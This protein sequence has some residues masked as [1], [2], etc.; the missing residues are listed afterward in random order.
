M[1]RDCIDAINGKKP[2]DL[3]IRNVRIINVFS[4][5]LQEGDIAICGDTIAYVGKM[6]FPNTAREELD[7]QG[8]YAIP[9]LID[10]HMHIESSMMVPARFA[11]LALACGTTTVAADPHEIGNVFGV[12]GV[13]ALS[14]AAAGSPLHVYMLAPSTIPSAP[15]LETTGASVGAKE[16]AEMLDLPHI[17]GMGEVMDFNGVADGEEDILSVVET[18]RTQG[19]LM[20]AHVTRL[21]GRRL[22]AFR[23]TGADADHTDT[24]IPYARE[25]LETGFAIQVQRTFL[26]AELME[27]LESYP[28]QDRIMLITDDVPFIELVR[29]GHLNA[30]LREAI[31]LGLDPIRAVR[32]ATLNAAD[33]LRLYDRGAVSPGYKADI[34]L[35]DK[36]EEMRPSLVLSDGRVAVKD[37]KCIAQIPDYTFPKHFYTSV[38]VPS[39][40]A[41][42]FV[43]RTET[44]ASKALVNTIGCGQVN[45]RTEKAEKWVPVKNGVLDTQELMKMAVIYRHGKGEEKAPEKKI[46][47]G[48]I[49]G[50]PEF[51]GAIATTY[52][53]DS[54]NL[55]IYGSCDED[56]ALAG[57]HLAEMGGGLCA[58]QDGKVVSQVSLPVAGLLSEELVETLRQEFE[59]FFAAVEKLSLVHEHPMTFLTLMALA[60]SPEIKCTDIGLVDVVNKK[61]LPLV[62]KAE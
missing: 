44:G 53:H 24:S 38:H 27:F 47:L 13:K 42:D 2:F 48:L 23:T 8:R 4:L 12:E 7:G 39:L 29:N 49:S 60:V 5:A 30:N 43:I 18:A 33:R 46:A 32:Y 17:Y 62:V 45:T 51:H 14:E 6:D 54:H 59:D 3:I 61:L 11:E 57:N 37:G 16:M 28:M 50:F 26:S 36:L 34:L 20:D 25:K 1:A 15:G 9:G 19:V 55:T 52:A 10:A 21:S 58:V 40:A 56:M 41:K 31:S 22:Q 35:L